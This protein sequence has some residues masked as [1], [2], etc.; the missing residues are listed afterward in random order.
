MRTV[1]R[2]IYFVRSRWAWLV[3]AFI[4]LAL[5][6]G[7]ALTIP[8]LLGKGIDTAL[9]E[10]DSNFFGIPMERQTAM[11]MVAVAVIVAS[12]LRG[13]ADYFR[14][15]LSQVVSQ[16]VTYDVRNAFYE[17]LQ[18]LSFAY[19]DHAQ[20]GQLMSRAT[21][22]VEAIRMFF[23]MGLVGIAELLVMVTAVTWLPIS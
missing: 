21:V 2:L 6:T 15:Y 3:G 18:R 12:L 10:A 4:C 14:T 8:R 17:R 22:D 11:L 23:A 9:M 16:K 19:H 5:S 13:V 1:F 20:T 7:F